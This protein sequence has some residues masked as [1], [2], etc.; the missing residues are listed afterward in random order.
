MERLRAKT[1]A[2]HRSEDLLST[3]SLLFD[4]FRQLQKGNISKHIDRSALA[5]VNEKEKRFDLWITQE[6]GTESNQK[7]RIDFS[8][9]THG[10]TLYQ[11]FQQKASHNVI[12]NIGEKLR[13]WLDYRKIYRDEDISQ[14]L[15]KKTD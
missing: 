4:Q 12:D 1:M 5:L 6:G 15:R 3:V 9:Q 10:I 13:Q 11:S 14:P 2:M 8:E 7:Y